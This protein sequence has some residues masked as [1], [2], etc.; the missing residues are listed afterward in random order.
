MALKRIY[1]NSE[2]PKELNLFSHEWLINMI[3]KDLKIF[4]QNVRK[5]NF[6]INTILEVN[7]N[8]DII[9]IQE[10]SWMTIRTISSLVNCKDIPLVGIPNHPN[11]L[12]FTKEPC[13]TIS[14]PRV[15]IYI[16]I[17]LSSFQFS[18]CKNVINHRDILLASFFND[19]NIFWIMNVYSDSSHSI[20]KYLMDTEVNI[21]NLLIMTGNFNIRDSIWDSSFPHHSSISDNLMIIADSFNLEL[22]ILTNQVPTRYLDMVSEANSVIDLMFLQSGSNE[23]NNHSIHPEWRLSS[24]HAPIMVSVPITE[25]NII[26]SKFSIV[27]NSEEEENFIKDVSS[28]IKSI[29]VSDLSDIDKLKDTTNSLTSS[30][31][32]A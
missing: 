25:E 10:P 14:F 27:K 24:D 31:E 32:N 28:I 5:N 20:L 22:S 23:L 9:F 6:L 29:K 21:S 11:W 8:F 16:N 30:I 7:Q 13:S 17:R 15:I 26:T 12:T 18:L 2:Q 1:K 4:S 3:L 19:N